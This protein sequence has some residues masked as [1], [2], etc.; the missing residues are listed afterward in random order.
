MISDLECSELARR[1]DT[2]ENFNLLTISA[3]AAAALRS[4]RRPAVFYA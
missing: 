1:L 2:K 4:H 3:I